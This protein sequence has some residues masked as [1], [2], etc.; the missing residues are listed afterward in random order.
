MA[1]TVRPLTAADR[2]A[3]EPLWTGYLQFEKM[4]LD[5]AISDL[6]WER[7]L[8][9]N[10][11]I[12]GALAFNQAGNAV[13]VVHFLT[14]RSTWSPTSYCYLE[15]LFVAEAARGLGAGRAL[16]EYVHGWAKD[17]GC[18]RVYWHMHHSNATARQLYDRIA[19]ES[20]LIEYRIPL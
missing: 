14:H 15:D 11:S 13:G 8:D 7:M 9:P 5:P 20:G 6:T 12:Y 17:A 10:E 4:A 3:W 1:V 19:T 16:I 2:K 18:K